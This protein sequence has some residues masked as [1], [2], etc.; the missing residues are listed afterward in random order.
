MVPSGAQAS[1]DRQIEL[2]LS[3]KQSPGTKSVLLSTDSPTP[4]LPQTAPPRDLDRELKELD[5][6]KKRA[7]VDTQTRD[8]E[9]K[10]S[11]SARWNNPVALAV[12]AAMIGYLG[13]LVT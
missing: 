10:N 7:E 6:L 4:P 8:L 13:I 12:I 11:W 9:A 3:K 5:V 2:T 1:V